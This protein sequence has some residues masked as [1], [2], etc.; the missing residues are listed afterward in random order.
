[1]NLTL[2]LLAGLFLILPGIGAVTAWNYGGHGAARRPELQLNSVTTLFALLVASVIAHVAGYFMVNLVRGALVEAGGLLGRVLGPVI[3]DP[4]VAA[5][6]LVEGPSELIA[7]PE[8]P[9]HALESLA[10]F[11][12]VVLFET[13]VAFSLVRNPGL[14]IYIEPFDLRGQ[15]W[16]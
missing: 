2:S 15:G 9:E 12:C 11:V 7:F 14:D 8:A 6:K 4:Y 5:L 3:P 13:V 10:T 16:V 1:M